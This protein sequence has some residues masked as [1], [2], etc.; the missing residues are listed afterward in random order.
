VHVGPIPDGLL[1][2][3]KCDTRSCGNPDHLFLGTHKDNSMDMWRKG[4]AEAIRESVRVRASQGVRSG[5]KGASPNAK[6]TWD[7]ANQIREAVGLLKEIARK[8]GVSPSAVSKIKTGVRWNVRD[9]P[10]GI[11]QKEPT[12]PAQ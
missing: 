11:N 12:P 9:R 2:C 7:Q 3:H 4:R 10:V 1:V 5:V 8:F 6:L